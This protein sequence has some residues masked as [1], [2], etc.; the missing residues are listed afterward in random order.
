MAT[1]LATPF[2]LDLGFSKT[3]IG[4]IAKNAGLWPSVIGGLLGGVWMMK[5]GIH[6]R[7]MAFW[8]SS[9]D[10]YF[11]LSLGSLT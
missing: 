8:F 10:Q 6:P 9:N 3:E 7:I 11:R 2:Y 4:L 1:A 5:L